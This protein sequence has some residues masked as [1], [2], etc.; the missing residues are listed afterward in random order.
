[1]NNL[2]L[3]DGH[4]GSGK[5]TVST[6]IESEIGCQKYSFDDYITEFFSCPAGYESSKYIDDLRI[7]NEIITD[8]WRNFKRNKN[9]SFRDSVETLIKYKTIIESGQCIPVEYA[10]LYLEA[11]WNGYLDLRDV[12]LPSEN[13]VIDAIVE[14]FLVPI[15]FDVDNAKKY[16][17]KLKV[18]SQIAISR[19]IKQYGWNR[20]TAENVI[21]RTSGYLKNRITPEGVILLE[22]V[23]NTEEDLERI[24]K[25]L[26]DKILKD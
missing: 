1:M 2:I 16:H 18:D 6:F 22:Y 26:K 17:V 21:E 11:F 23:N 3:V 24:K 9:Y 20:Q 14:N 13:V 15:I 10:K 7:E 12:S 4:S 25:D 8:F 5:T 19:K